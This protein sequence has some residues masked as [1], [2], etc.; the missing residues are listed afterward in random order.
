MIIQYPHILYLNPSIFNI[1]NICFLLPPLCMIILPLRKK[2]MHP[3]KCNIPL[4]HSVDSTCSHM[5]ILPTF[6]QS[7]CMVLISPI[8]DPISDCCLRSAAI[9]TQSSLIRRHGT[10]QL[11]FCRLH[12]SWLFCEPWSKALQ[13]ASWRF[14]AVQFLLYGEV[15][16]RRWW[17][18]NEWSCVLPVPHGEN[19]EP[20]FPLHV[21][22]LCSA[23]LS[24]RF[25]PCECTFSLW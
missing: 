13:G 16:L 1:F 4:F 10:C 2:G 23:W 25:L 9:R 20:Q 17:L 24:V 14:G 22:A 18:E 7:K 15:Q 5:Q 21:G 8:H 19:M 6:L 11:G 12:I 3:K